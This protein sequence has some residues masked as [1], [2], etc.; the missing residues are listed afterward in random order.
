MAEIGPNGVC[1]DI[2]RIVHVHELLVDVTARGVQNG[3]RYIHAFDSFGAFVAYLTEQFPSST[4]LAPG[5][6]DA[7][8]MVFST[9]RLLDERFCQKRTVDGQGITVIQKLHLSRRAHLTA[10]SVLGPVENHAGRFLEM[11]CQ[12]WG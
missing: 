6:V 5:I 9:Y 11:G 4:T 1:F 2:L 7:D 12:F 3:S 8:I 10:S